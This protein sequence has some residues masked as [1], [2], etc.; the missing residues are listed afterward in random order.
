MAVAG[1]GATGRNSGDG[2]M[3][4]LSMVVTEVLAVVVMMTKRLCWIVIIVT[5]PAC[6]HV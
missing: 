2:L 6:M 5:L 3:A 1:S 4:M